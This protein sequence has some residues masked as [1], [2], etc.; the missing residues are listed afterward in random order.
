VAAEKSSLTE[1]ELLDRYMRAISA[2]ALLSA[3]EEADV[4]ARIRPR[5][6]ARVRMIR[7][8][9]KLVVKI[10]Y[11]YVGMGSFDDLSRGEF[12]L[13][14]R[15][16]VRPGAGRAFGGYAPGG[17]ACTFARRSPTDQSMRLRC[18]WLKRLR[19]CVERKMILWRAGRDDRRGAHQNHALFA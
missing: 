14:R 18:T 8:N 13:I 19:G 10:A 1:R 11:D 9:L 16:S 4:A 15:W 2:T 5:C 12:G 17:F 3:Q 6:A 7:A